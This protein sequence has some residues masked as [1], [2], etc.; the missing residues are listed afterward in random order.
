[1]VRPNTAR[2]LVVLLGRM[3][4]TPLKVKQAYAIAN[5]RATNFADIL[6]PLEQFWL[7]TLH[8]LTSNYQTTFT[9]AAIRPAMH[10]A[11]R[12][13]TTSGRRL[14]TKG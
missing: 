12:T 14:R 2:T 7:H 9:E 10:S 1:M 3:L 13:A 8:L 5:M 4:I 11:V 6:G